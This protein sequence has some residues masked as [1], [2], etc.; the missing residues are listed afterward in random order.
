[1]SNKL[2]K[3]SARSAQ[4]SGCHSRKAHW[5]VHPPPPALARVK[6]PKH[7]PQDLQS[8]PNVNPGPPLCPLL[9]HGCLTVLFT[10]KEH[11]LFP[12]LGKQKQI[13]TETPSMRW[14]NPVSIDPDYCFRSAHKF[15]FVHAR[16]YLRNAYFK[17]TIG[18]KQYE[19]RKMCHEYA[20][21]WRGEA[22]SI[23]AFVIASAVIILSF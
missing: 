9:P 21:N 5:G 17:F 8:L 7:R 19:T 13:G 14:T 4:Q 15:K 11:W 18:N 22:E 10:V 23:N 16:D 20:V 3:I 1:M 2:C 6:W 12:T